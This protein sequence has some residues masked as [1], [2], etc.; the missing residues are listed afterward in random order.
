MECVGG[1]LNEA[2]QPSGVTPSVDVQQMEGGKKTP[3]S[4]QLS[5]L[6]LKLERANQRRC[7]SSNNASTYK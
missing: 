3:A 2:L 4:L 1:F 6:I 7:L 5:T